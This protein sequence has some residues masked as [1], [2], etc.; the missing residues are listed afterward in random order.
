MKIIALMPA[1]NEEWILKT[2]LPQLK[3]FVDEILVLDGQSTD[4]TKAIVERFQGIAYEQEGTEVHYSTW[5]QFLLTKGR[6]RGGTHFVWL[7]ADEAFTT[8]FLPTFRSRL[9][10]LRPGQKLVLDWL[11]LWKDPRQVRSDGSVY[12]VLPKD[13]VFCDD[14]VSGFNPATLHEGRTPGPNDPER[15]L[16][17]PREEGA[18][19]HFQF[20]PFDRFQIKQAYM[21]CRELVMKTAQAWEINEKYAIT[22]DDP[23]ARCV[24]APAAWLEGITGLDDLKNQGQGW[25]EQGVLDYFERQGPEFFEPLEIWHV[26]QFR[27]AFRERVGR[28]PCSAPRPSTARRFA[29]RAARK[30]RRMI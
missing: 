12:S 1:K 8:N 17:I 24:P 26:P 7:D 15:S 10:Q 19:L 11:C 2:T 29:L 22:L 9:E 14:G 3:R 25:Y 4:G 27:A 23:A 13:F 5:R 6:E 28:E 21:R 20:V 18:V 30:L 16:R